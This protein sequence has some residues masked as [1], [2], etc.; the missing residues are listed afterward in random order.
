MASEGKNITDLPIL[1]GANSSTMLV[2]SHTVGGVSNTYQLSVVNLFIPGTPANSTI[3]V[4]KGTVMYDSNYLYV[5]SANNT[6][7]RIPLVAF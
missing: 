7:K 5:A 3:T 1:T 6:L 4:Q 2:V